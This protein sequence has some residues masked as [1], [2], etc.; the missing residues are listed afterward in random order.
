MREQDPR[1]VSTKLQR[2]AEL[3]RRVR[4]EPL[5]HITHH[6]DIEFL[7]EAFRRTRKDGA[8]GVDGQTAEEYAAKLEENLE[9]LHERCSEPIHSVSQEGDRLDPVPPPFADHGTA[10][11]ARGEASRALRILRDHRELRGAGT[12]HLRGG[13]SMAEVAQP[14]LSTE[15]DALGPL[16]AAPSAVP[17]P[18]A[19]R[20][21]PRQ[22]SRGEPV[23]RGAGCRR[24]ARPDLWGAGRKPRPPRQ[25]KTVDARLRQ[26][27]IRGNSSV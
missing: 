16:P 18:A 14:P 11:G 22:P 23:I 20:R 8:T 17:A 12:L 3:A 15:E 13:T 25:L 26:L 1:D 27:R 4:N 21:S 2:V 7:K 19:T 10:Q 6:I 24:S 9:S 5:N